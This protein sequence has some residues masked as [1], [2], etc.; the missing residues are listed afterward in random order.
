MKTCGQPA[1]AVALTSRHATTIIC[2]LGGWQ[3]DEYISL[4]ADSGFSAWIRT[5]HPPVNSR[6][7]SPVRSGRTRFFGPL[8]GRV[9]AQR[10]ASAG[11]QNP[12]ETLATTTAT[13][14]S[15]PEAVAEAVQ[16]GLSLGGLL[17]VAS[18]RKRA[19]A[20]SHKALFSP[21]RSGFHDTRQRDSRSSIERTVDHDHA[22]R[23]APVVK[24]RVSHARGHRFESCSAHHLNYL[25]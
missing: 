6:A 4:S 14:H 17:S 12:A 3:P 7:L 5:R 20:V 22:G 19:P 23:L 16:G 8:L 11:K 1:E 10:G 2:S 15:V 9:R 13:D 18:R 21:A 25:K 24:A